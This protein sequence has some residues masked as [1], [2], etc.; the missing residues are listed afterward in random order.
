VPAVTRSGS[1]I[2]ELL[3]QEKTGFSLSAMSQ[4]DLQVV[5]DSLWFM[6]RREAQPRRRLDP[7][8]GTVTGFEIPLL[9]G[10]DFVEAE[11]I[12]TDPDGVW[13][14][15]SRRVIEPGDGEG[16]S[17]TGMSDVDQVDPSTGEFVRSIF[18]GEL[19][20]FGT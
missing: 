12:P 4:V 17:T 8:T 14:S 19:T 5:G 16:P 7:S 9:E 10:N 2:G 18:E 6:D 20:G 11:P 1:G 15:T 3:D 13:L